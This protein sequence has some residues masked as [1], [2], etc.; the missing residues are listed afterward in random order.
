M[1]RMA[2]AMMGDV[3]AM[4]QPAGRTRRARRR[5]MGSYEPGK[6]RST[7][8]AFFLRETYVKRLLDAQHIPD[9]SGHND[10]M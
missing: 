7:P 2:A 3:M 6:S 10:E 8:Q 9:K 4:M 1:A 5:K